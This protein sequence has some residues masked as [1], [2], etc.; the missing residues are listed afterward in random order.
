MR[1]QQLPATEIFDFDE[2][3]SER[4]EAV[5]SDSISAYMFAILYIRTNNS[6]SN[7]FLIILG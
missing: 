5:K 7:Y 1:K 3:V 4:F 6:E 2:S